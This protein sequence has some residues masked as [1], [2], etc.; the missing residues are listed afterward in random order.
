MIAF[1]SGKVSLCLGLENMT[2]AHSNYFP[3]VK[4]QTNQLAVCSHGLLTV[5]LA[6]A[7][8]E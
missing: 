8:K 5:C 4:H 1:L 7:H 3:P 2:C 6:L